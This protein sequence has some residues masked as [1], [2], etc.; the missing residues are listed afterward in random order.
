MT[1]KK[2]AATGDKAPDHGLVGGF[3]L[4]GII[5]PE[6]GGGYSSGQAAGGHRGCHK[7][8]EE[9]DG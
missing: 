4:L 2:T 5:G 9:L 7:S 8:L 3:L 6:A 1:L